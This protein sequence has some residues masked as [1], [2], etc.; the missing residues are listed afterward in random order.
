MILLLLLRLIL[1]VYTNKLEANKYL[2]FAK[3]YI[4]FEIWSAKKYLMFLLVLAIKMCTYYVFTFLS[5]LLTSP[6]TLCCFLSKHMLLTVF[7]PSMF[8]FNQYQINVCVVGW[9]CYYDVIK[10][11]RASSQAKEQLK[12]QNM[13]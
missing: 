8:Q 9:N 7:S 1:V 2:M 6:S 5:C 11:Y 4:C 3:L 13:K 10:L 12:L